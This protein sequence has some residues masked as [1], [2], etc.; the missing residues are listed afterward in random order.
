MADTPTTSE[1]TS[2]EPDAVS[3]PAAVAEVN[4]VHLPDWMRSPQVEH[5]PTGLDRLRFFSARHNGPLLVGF[6]LVLALL[7]VV[8]GAVLVGRVADG[9]RASATASPTPSPTLPVSRVGEPRDL[10]IG[11]PAASFAAGEKAVRMPAAND[12]G[13][14]SAKEVSVALESVRKALIKGRLDR[15]M[16]VG[17]TEPF[18]ALLAPDARE[19][20]RSNFADGSFLRYATRM[21]SQS[22]W[23]PDPRA[24]GRISYRATTEENGVRLLEVTTEFVWAYPFDVNL[25]APAGAGLVA[26][27]DRVVWQVPH[28]DD[29]QAS[30]RGLWIGSAEAVTWNADCGQLRDG[31]VREQYWMAS[32]HGKRVPA[33]DPGTIFD[34][35]APAPSTTRC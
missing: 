2:P 1:P 6:G 4:P 22:E 27:R 7:M 15:S 31:W 24:A 8:G 10:F 28:P 19:Q 18:L 29:V 16:F 14:F 25:Q 30:S 32:L 17:D 13:P 21:S 3:Q 26:I 11:T 35:D 34:L 20:L 33:G 5:Q 12:S 23:E 9:V